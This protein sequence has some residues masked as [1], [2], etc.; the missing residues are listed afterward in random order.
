[1]QN[2]IFRKKTKKSLKALTG[3]SDEYK[4]LWKICQLVF[5]L[6]HGQ[7]YCERGFSINKLTS[8]DNMDDDTLIA[9]RLIYDAIKKL[10]DVAEIQISKELRK[11]CKSAYSQ[12]VLDKSRKEQEKLLS[13]RDLKGKQN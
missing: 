12:M 6:N 1:M 8:S 2:P 3:I 13:E 10:G 7:A 11:S 5:V 9:Q 4:D